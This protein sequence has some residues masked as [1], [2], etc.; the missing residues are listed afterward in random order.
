MSLEHGSHGLRENPFRNA[1]AFRDA[2]RHRARSHAGAWERYSN[3]Y[4]WFP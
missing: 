2:E 1:P 4:L 3:S